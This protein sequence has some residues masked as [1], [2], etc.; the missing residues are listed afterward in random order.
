MSFF[1]LFYGNSAIFHEF[2]EGMSR[3]VPEF[4]TK[5]DDFR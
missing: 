1:V 3:T 5:Y 4:S 2:L